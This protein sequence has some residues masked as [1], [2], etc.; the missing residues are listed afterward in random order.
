MTYLP[1]E[2]ELKEEIQKNRQE[3]E[4]EKRLKS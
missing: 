1:T 2:Q 4:Q 3:I